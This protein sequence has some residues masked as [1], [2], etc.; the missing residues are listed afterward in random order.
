MRVQFDP[1][2]RRTV[3]TANAAVRIADANSGR[4]GAGV[5]QVPIAFEVQ[6]PVRSMRLDRALLIGPLPI[7]D[8]GVR[9]ADFGSAAGISEQDAQPSDPDEIVVVGTRNPQK[10]FDYIRIGSDYLDRCSSITFDK[11]AKQVRL[12]CLKTAA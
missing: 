4:L 11:A 3:A 10:K 2:H 12:T 7:R 5:Q 9:T 8:L 6:R 1:A